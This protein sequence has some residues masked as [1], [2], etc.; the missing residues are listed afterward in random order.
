MTSTQSLPNRVMLNLFQ[1][2]IYILEIVDKTHVFLPFTDVPFVP[3]K[4][5][6]FQVRV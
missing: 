1:H 6:G 2:L 4:G 3:L 5:K